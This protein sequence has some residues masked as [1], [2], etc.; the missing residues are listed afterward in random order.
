M[1]AP[2]VVVMKLETGEILTFNWLPE[3]ANAKS[4]MTISTFKASMI[5]KMRAMIGE[6]TLLQKEVTENDDLNDVA[7]AKPAPA[8]ETAAQAAPAAKKLPPGAVAM[9][10][11]G[12]PGG[13]KLPGMGGK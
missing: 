6:K 8:A 10:G 9:P 11:M 12:P 5:E 3:N 1:G 2:R 4:K 13:F 7:D